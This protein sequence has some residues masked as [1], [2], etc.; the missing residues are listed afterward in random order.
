MAEIVAVPLLDAGTDKTMLR[1]TFRS[2]CAA[3][4]EAYAVDNKR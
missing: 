1:M 4:G 3:P 2:D